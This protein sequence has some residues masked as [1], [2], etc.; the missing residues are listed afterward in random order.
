MLY[1]LAIFAMITTTICN[2]VN[3]TNYVHM[4]EDYI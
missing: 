3:P 4:H 1:G 2:Y